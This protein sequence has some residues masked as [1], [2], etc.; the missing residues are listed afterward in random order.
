MNS[1]IVGTPGSTTVTVTWD[2]AVP[3]GCKD[4]A[5]LKR[6]L[7][8]P[9]RR[10]HAFQMAEFRRS[11]LENNIRSA[12]SDLDRATDKRSRPHILVCVKNTASHDRRVAEY[13]KNLNRLA[14]LRSLRAALGTRG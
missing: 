2:D 9:A 12:N 1:L 5:E 13:Q 14:T 3:C 10:Q 6:F 8:D 7:S 11:H 4:C